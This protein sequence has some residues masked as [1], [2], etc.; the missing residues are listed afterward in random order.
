MNAMNQRTTAPPTVLL[1]GLAATVGDSTGVQTFARYLWQ[2]KQAVRQWLT[3]LSEG[4]S[5]EFIV[6]EHVEDVV[7]V[8][9]EKLRFL[10]LKTRDRGS[11]SA[12]IMCDEGLDSLIRSYSQARDA[13]L[14]IHASFELWLEGPISNGRD[15]PSFVSKPAT[16]SDK[17]KAKLLDNGAQ[18]EWLDD[19]LSRLVIKPN[20]PP[21][22]HIDAIIIREVACLW[23]ALSKPELDNLY[24]MLLQAATAAQG[25]QQRPPILATCLTAAFDSARQQQCWTSECKLALE[26]IQL[27]ILSRETLLTMTPPRPTE[28]PAQV[29][30]RMK[31][32]SDASMLE[33]KM[34]IAGAQQETIRN[35]KDFRAQMEFK[36]QILLAS[37]DN[38]QESLDRLADRVLTVARATAKDIQLSVTVNPV[39]ASKP[40]EVIAAR[41]LSQPRILGD[42]DYEHIFDGD[43]FMIYGYL[44]HLSDLCCYPWQAA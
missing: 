20:Q 4:S 28:L 25:A 24:N 36:R 5:P 22:A 38:A 31:N 11:W 14:H 13:G 12:S 21:R 42:L 1:E 2:A 18:R 40:A 16:A 32:G 10:Q 34:T 9:N 37:R 41:M 23:P 35:A 29:L 27:Q 39:A 3:C 26:P 30:A 19:F 7:L 15:T 6:C 44:S 17:I 43:G 8:L 33:L